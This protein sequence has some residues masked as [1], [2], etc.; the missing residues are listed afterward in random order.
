MALPRNRTG[1]TLSETRHQ[2]CAEGWE[3]QDHRAA[4]LLSY[5]SR[6]M[7]LFSAPPPLS[8]VEVSGQPQRRGPAQTRRV[9]RTLL[10]EQKGACIRGVRCEKPALRACACPPNRVQEVDLFPMVCAHSLLL[11]S[12]ALK[13]TDL[14]FQ[15]SST[16]KAR[17]CFQNGACNPRHVKQGQG[18]SQ[19]AAPAGAAVGARPERAGTAPLGLV[20]APH[21]PGGGHGA[22]GG[23]GIAR[24]RGRRDLKAHIGIS[25]LAFKQCSPGSYIFHSS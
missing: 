7:D 19:R 25:Y 18:Q 17:N 3:A 12:A 4:H 5:H 24:Q 16:A 2:R 21:Q 22:R 8:H 14:G 9:A 15:Q 23:H 11:A 20:P 1:S 13:P 6:D 10:G